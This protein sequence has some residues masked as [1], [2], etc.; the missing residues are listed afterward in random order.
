MGS[1]PTSLIQRSFAAGEVGP[2]VY[3]RADQVKYSTGLAKC[4]N[5][6]VRRHG[7]VSNRSGTL[8]LNGQRD[9][10]KKGRILPFVFNQDQTYVLLFEEG[11]LRFIRN[12]LLLTISGVPAWSGAGA[13]VSAITQAN[14]CEITTSAAH[15]F[16]N[17]Q[18]IILSGIVGVSTKSITGATNANPCVITSVAHGFANGQ[19][20]RITGVGG[21]TELNGNTYT[22]ANKTAN[23]FELS[24]VDSSTYGVYTTGGNVYEDG[25]NMSTL[26]GPRF[27]VAN[28]TAT[29]FELEGFDTSGFS[30]YVS[31][32]TATPTY[33][34]GDV[35][36]SGGINYYC[37]LTHVNHVP[38]NATY[39]Y[40]MPAGNIYEIPTP[41]LEADL[42]TLYISQSADV[43]TITHPNYRPR[44]LSRFDH[45]DWILSIV[46]N[47]PSIDPP[48]SLSVSG[49][50]GNASRWVVTATAP[51]TFDES[52]PSP[53]DGAN[54]KPTSGSPRTLTIG[55][56]AG[57][58]EYNVYRHDGNGIY[59]FIGTAAGTTFIDDGIPPNYDLTPPSERDPFV[60]AGDYPAISGYL[61]QRKCYGGMVNDPE[62]VRASRTGLFTNFT[63]SLPLQDDMAA[64]WT[65]NSSQVNTIRHVL[66]VG[67]SFILTSG[68]E[69]VAFGDGSGVLTPATPGLKKQSEHGSSQL[70]P[71]VIGSSFL[72]VQ[73]RGSIVRDVKFEAQSNGYAGRDLTV[74]SPHLFEGRTLVHWAYAQIPHS[75]VH[76]VRDDGALLAFTYLRD[77]EVWG[78]TIYDTDG[79]IEDVCVIPLGT[80][81]VTYV[82][83]KRTING[84]TKRYLE[85]FASRE[86]DDVTVDAKFMDSHLTYDG[87]YTGG[88]ITMTLT[89]SGWTHDDTVTLTASAGY[90]VSGDAGKSIRLTIE[91]ETYTPEEG[92]RSSSTSV[93]VELVT[94]SSATV[95]TVRPVRTIPVAFQ[96]VAIAT[97]AKGVKQVSGLDHLEG[98]AVAILGDGN[99]LTNGIDAPL[100]TI[101]G[102]SFSTALER[103][104]YVIHAGL[105]YCSDFQTLDL[106]VLGTETLAD[107][108][109]TVN[110]VTLLVEA[111]RGVWAGEPNQDGSVRPE[112]LFEHQQRDVADEYGTMALLTGKV[113]ISIKTAWNLGGRVH[114]RQRDPL[115][116]SILAIMPSVTAG[117]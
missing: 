111:S 59:G 4:R 65:P 44:D 113:E 20:V 101:S 96:A 97:W 9:H 1:G 108:R 104:Y 40:P 92:L 94:Y 12:D 34:V 91:T 19:I 30:S 83:V 6:F 21:M 105:P 100:T 60:D 117:G 16:A 70:P 25:T 93:E 64:D 84:V 5:M 18:P 24:G 32:G 80:E 2:A 43:I 35:V 22:V 85:R 109:K 71:I 17:G 72:F 81:D 107:K 36:V 48:P 62:T 46:F 110:T 27:L 73:A 89:G 33:E 103:W 52:L 114:V 79:E 42:P 38:P 66:E 76:A 41:Y 77:H 102:G 45:T 82:L 57:A 87:R 74:F 106:E 47:D 29:T 54:S 37:I 90:F 49:T 63:K 28:V 13:T 23:T 3:G 67:E 56:V 26:N 69:W 78:W 88:A 50:G 51:E 68:A 58:L 112:D 75:V 115:P 39:W 116:L 53:S 55:A 10:T 8:Y 61:Q 99:V 31:G 98:K 7:G 95:F 86:V 11:T 15:G 14:P